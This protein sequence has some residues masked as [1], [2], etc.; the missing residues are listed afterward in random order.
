MILCHFALIIGRQSNYLN[1]DLTDIKLGY[2]F[3]ARLLEGNMTNKFF[4]L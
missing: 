4:I 3:N 2:C 1:V